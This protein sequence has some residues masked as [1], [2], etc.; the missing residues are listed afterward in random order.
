MTH[1]TEFPLPGAPGPIASQRRYFA[2]VISMPAEVADKELGDVLGAS[3]ALGN[4]ARAAEASFLPAR[5]HV[6][7]SI[8]LTEEFAQ[9][10]W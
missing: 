10:P 7:R 4:M 8:E 5:A 3:T 1:R 6:L 2:L 9:R